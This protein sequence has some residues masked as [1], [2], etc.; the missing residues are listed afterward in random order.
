MALSAI[1]PSYAASVQAKRDK[2]TLLGPTPKDMKRAEFEL[3]YTAE[4]GFVKVTAQVDGHNVDMYLYPTMNVCVFS[5]AQI[6]QVDS[7][8]LDNSGEAVG[9]PVD[10]TNNNNVTETYTRNFRLRR[11]KLGRIETSNV[12]AQI[13]ETIGRGGVTLGN[14]ERP[15]L[16]NC[17]TQGWRWEVLANRRMLRFTQM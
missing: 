12:P 11:V 17:A 10:P 2:Y 13:V 4:N 8:Y 15:I 7:S 16:G 6:S 1:D 3:P 14:F 9:K 5:T